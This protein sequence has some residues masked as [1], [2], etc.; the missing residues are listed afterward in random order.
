MHDIEVWERSVTE[1]RILLGAVY[2]VSMQIIALFMIINIIYGVT[3]T[4]EQNQRWL[5]S[6]LMGVAAGVCGACPR[7]VW[8][9]D[10]AGV[11]L[12]CRLRV[13]A[14][15]AACAHHHRRVCTSRSQG[16]ARA[17]NL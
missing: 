13:L 11:W 10:V 4:G 3:F 15:A 5:T 14:A 12:P 6:V 8:D 9:G 7:D 17:R 16:H 2:L 1:R